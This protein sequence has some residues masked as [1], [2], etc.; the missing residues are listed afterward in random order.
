MTESRVD[1]S[2]QRAAAK[3]ARHAGN[4]LLLL[5]RGHVLSGELRLH[6]GN[7]LGVKRICAVASRRRERPGNGRRRVAGVLPS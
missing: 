1:L 7:D 4:H 6:V 5:I 3:R 2:A